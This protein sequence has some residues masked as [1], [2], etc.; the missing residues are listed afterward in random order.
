MSLTAIIAELIE[1][2]G[3]MPVSD[4]M[5]MALQHPEHGYYR[6]GNP[7]GKGGDFT[8]APEISQM[9]GEMVGL[10]CSEIWRMMGS[11][12]HVTLLE[13][14]PGRGTLMEDALR[15]TRRINLFH[16][17]VD[18]YL[19]ESSETLRAMQ[20]EKLGEFLPHH[21]DDFSQISAQPLIIVANEFFDALPIRQFEKGFEGWCER[22]VALKEGK[23]VFALSQP[24]DALKLLIPETMHDAVPGT[25][26][27]LCPAAANVM[28]DL[29]TIVVRNGGAILTI[30]YGYPAP[31]GKPTLQALKDHK[32]ADVLDSPGEVDVTALV[33]FGLLRRAALLQK[34]SV[35]GP[36]GQGAFLQAMGIDIRAAGL[37]QRAT[38]QQASDIDTGLRRLTDAAEMG[39]L[40]KAMA[41]TSPN[42]NPPGFE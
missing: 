1:K 14:G 20:K 6:R 34:A 25:V 33:D 38:A 26:Y 41:V 29:A 19:L 31:D 40:F 16:R 36:V 37:K 30:D 27:E 13:L 21:I 15:A 42:L 39:T 18:L 12:E 5:R 10:W 8:T 2:N 22:M 35:A 24:D 28:R 32:Y 9:F 4:Y 11:P 17:A 7:L 3:P 23:L